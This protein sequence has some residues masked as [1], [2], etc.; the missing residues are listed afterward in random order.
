MPTMPI[1]DGSLYYEIHGDGPPLMLASG[2]GGVGSY[3]APQIAAWSRHFKIIVHDHRGTGQSSKDKIAYSVAQMA[4][5]TLDLADGL[6]IERFHFAGHSTGG[7]IGQLLAIHHGDRLLSAVLSAS[8]MRP[9]PW[10]VRCFE[11]RKLLLQASGPAAYVRGQA[12]FLYPPWWVA[13]NAAEI[14]AMETKLIANFSLPDIVTS[15]INAIVA[16]DPGANAFRGVK[17]PCLVTCAN[18]DHL[19]PPHL[20]LELHAAIPGSTL[21]FTPK[22][23]HYNTVICAADF[24]ELALGWLQA[25]IAGT[26][27]TPPAGTT[28]DTIHRAS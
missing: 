8:W 11:T 19:T 26:P 2:L 22:G 24:N 28:T 13:A 5:D 3:W 21:A 15:R 1:T 6:G 20:S 14:A 4:R 18:D 16:H 17:T 12:L 23:G 27:W 7:A 25:T 9:D 10:F